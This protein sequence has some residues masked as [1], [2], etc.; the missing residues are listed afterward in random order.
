M[1]GAVYLALAAVALAAGF[2]AALSL[3]WT[4]TAAVSLTLAGLL[5]AGR[6]SVE[7]TRQRQ[8]ADNYLR[9]MRHCAPTSRYAWRA[10]E[11]TS[12]RG[13]RALARSLRRVVGEV[14][15]R[16]LPGAVPINRYG[17][18]PHVGDLLRLA[19]ALADTRTR[20]TPAGILL[21][22]DLFTSPAGPLYVRD[23]A[24]EVPQTIATILA[25]LVVD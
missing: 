11:L 6:A 1:V 16:L 20:V 18:R 7:L 9:T 17:L 4:L 2:G 12:E 21:V 25:S 24:G 14:N 10:D 22:H 15:G 5:H 13:R 19:R 23:R 8:I 3:D